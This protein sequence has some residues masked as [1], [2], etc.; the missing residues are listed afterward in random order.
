MISVFLKFKWKGGFGA[1]IDFLH[2][3]F[4]F[5]HSIDSNFFFSVVILQYKKK[6]GEEKAARDIEY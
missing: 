6:Y 4:D 2:L 5:F 3:R 1:K